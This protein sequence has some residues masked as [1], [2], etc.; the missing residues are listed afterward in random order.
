MENDPIN[1]IRNILQSPRD[2]S[3]KVKEVW[4]KFARMRNQQA[5][6]SW[7]DSNYIAANY[8]NMAISGRPDV[9]WLVDALNNFVVTEV[10]WALNL[11]CGGGD[12]ELYAKQKN[13][14]RNFDSIDISP[15]AIRVAIERTS[16]ENLKGLNFR[17]CNINDFESS[18]NKYD[19]VF[20]AASLHHFDKLEVVFEK[21]KTCLKK[22]GFF[23][24]SEYVGPSRFQWTDEQLEIM[25]DIIKMLPSSFRIDHL[26]NGGVKEEIRRMS[27]QEM[28]LMDPSEAIRSAEIIPLT[29]KNFRIVKRVDYGGT[30]LFMLLQGI[31]PNFKL[32]DP[33]DKS[34]F[35]LILYLER[36]L[37]ESKV[38]SSDFAYVV[39]KNIK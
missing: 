24:Y 22:D 18:E 17:A 30:L 19:V 32:S 25:N 33:K 26:Q 12:I 1:K 15:E 36:K 16:K 7:T 13:M 20:A 38:L 28:I 9:N 6:L 11:G 34:I 21:V 3:V 10:N 23:V 2:A 5:E 29:E 14:V 31:I 39:A 37:I 27:I 8:I 35:D 4:G